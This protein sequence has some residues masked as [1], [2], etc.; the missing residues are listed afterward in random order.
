M[1]AAVAIL[2]RLCMLL[3]LTPGIGAAQA[4]TAT[5]AVA[6]NFAEAA[7][8]LIARFEALNDHRITLVTGSTGKLFAQIIEGAPFDAFLAADQAR[9]AR[10]EA[11]GRAV[12]ETRF[13]YAEGRLV[14]WSA[15]PGVITSDGA[16]VLRAGDFAH[17]AIAN[18]DLAP[19]GLAAKQALQGLG[20][21]EALRPKLVMGQNIGQAFSMVATGNAELGLVAKSYAISTRNRQ[22]GGLWDVPEALYDPIRQDAVL[23]TE[24]NVAARDFLAYLKAPEARAVIA[25]YGYHV[26]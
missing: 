9:P 22:S 21:W 14:L 24:T 13:T 10:L 4:E 1:R 18:P 25:G 7:E 3:L 20:L 5:I 19:Y 6:T 2:R 23:L 11:E 15:T 8:D 16:T 17:L 26:E 12:V